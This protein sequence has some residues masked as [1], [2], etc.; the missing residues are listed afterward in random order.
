MTIPHDSMYVHRLLDEAFAGVEMTPERQ[1]LKDEVRANLVARVAE[2][3]A[4][5]MPADRGAR[6]AVEELGDLRALI[7][8]TESAAPWYQQRV[9]PRPGFVVRTVA[10]STLGIAG[11]AVLA[12]EATVADVPLGGAIAAG[13]AVAVAA[14]AI[15]ADA[16]RQETNHNHPMPVRR[17]AAYG[18]GVLLVVA[19]LAGGWLFVRDDGVGW[20]IGGIVLVLA[21]VGLLSYLGAT[22]TNRHKQW[23]VRMQDEHREVG[24]RFSRDPAAAARFGI[25]TMVNWLVT[26][27][28]FIVLTLTVGWAWSWIAVVGGFV[29]MMIMLARMLFVPGAEEAGGAEKAANSVNE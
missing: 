29:V 12:L 7:D 18:I 8:G 15:T 24:D 11:L 22:Q 26:V 5:G 25:Y 21:A 27:T 28:V 2:L 4:E 6:Q 14:G 1:E 19:G 9:R 20:L 16:L 23:V 13:L 17:A 3:E 10:L